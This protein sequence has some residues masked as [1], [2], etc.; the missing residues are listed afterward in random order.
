[1]G[2]RIEF[3]GAD[4]IRLERLVANG[5]TAQKHARRARIILLTAA[6]LSNTETARQ[7][8]TSLP[9]VRR[10]QKRF[11]EAGVDGLLKDATRSPGTPPLSPETVEKVV[12]LTLQE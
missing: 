5:N 4:R 10:W 6:G 2:T 1:M 11:Q 3:R 12:A 7:S 8:R 9:T